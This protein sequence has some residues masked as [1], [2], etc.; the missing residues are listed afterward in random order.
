MMRTVNVAAVSGLSDVASGCEDS[1][2][3]GLNPLSAE[4]SLIPPHNTLSARHGTLTA[5]V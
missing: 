5:V 4:I 3:F 1:S 2:G